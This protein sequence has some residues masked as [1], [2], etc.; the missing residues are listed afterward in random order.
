MIRVTIIIDVVV[1]GFFSLA[2]EFI[3]MSVIVGVIL[4]S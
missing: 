3:F 1:V 2:I 4:V